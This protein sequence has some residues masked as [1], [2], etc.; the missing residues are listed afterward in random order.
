M[1]LLLFYSRHI[2][3]A[4]W[5]SFVVSHPP[6]RRAGSGALGA[7]STTICCC[8]NVLR[9]TR[10][11]SWAFCFLP[12]ESVWMDWLALETI[13]MTAVPLNWP[14]FGKRDK[15]L[16]Y[17]WNDSSGAECLV[18]LWDNSGANRLVHLR[19]A[20]QTTGLR[21]GMKEVLTDWLTLEQTWRQLID[22]IAF[23]ATVAP[24]DWLI[25]GTFSNW[26]FR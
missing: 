14:S 1:V 5:L 6:C 9:Y 16:A 8:N 22:W 25:S 17:L 10:H 18:S 26:F 20:R 21:L 3:V 2:F 4:F 15:R 11:T 24:I 12:S 23:G 19:K 13:V 7:L